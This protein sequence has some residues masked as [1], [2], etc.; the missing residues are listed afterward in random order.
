LTNI[1]DQWRKHYIIEEDMLE[2][3][4]TVI[5]LSDVLKTSGHVD[6][7]AD[8]MV[9]DVQNGEIY[10]ADHLVEGV[11]DARLKGDKEARGVKEEVKVEEEDKKKK[12]KK[13]VKSEAVKLEDSVVEEYESTLA[14]VSSIALDS[15]DSRSTTLVVPSL[16]N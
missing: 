9:K 16:V 11:L 13:A 1:V 8:W 6:K 3:D 4:T 10:R 15:A 12:K 7:F 5:T 14:Q 2:L